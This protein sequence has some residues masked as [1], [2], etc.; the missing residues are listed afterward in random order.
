MPIYVAGPNSDAAR[1][2]ELERAVR[3]LARGEPPAEVIDALSQRLTNK[4]LHA[5]MR[6]LNRPA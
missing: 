1:R 3:R 6:A 4:L 5:P 2:A